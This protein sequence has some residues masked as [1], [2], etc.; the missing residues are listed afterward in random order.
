MSE[1][2]K[3]IVH[4]SFEEVWNQGKLVVADEIYDASFV[5]HG[6]GVE[7]PP[8]PEGF[9]Q[10]VSVYRSAFPDLHFTIEDQ[11]AEG[12][13]VVARWTARGT[14]K[15]EL[16]GIPATGKP[17]VVTGIDIY[18]IRSGKAVESWINWDALGMMQQLGVIP[19]MGQGGE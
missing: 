10:F 3:A 6:L 11:F 2:N 5:A 12:D 7:L 13:R 17:V 1:V 18:H 19:P 15:G 14:H 4:R 9:K 8:G 16:M